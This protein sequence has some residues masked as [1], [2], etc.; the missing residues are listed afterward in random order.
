LLHA[1]VFCGCP[2]MA[3]ESPAELG[4]N[5]CSLCPLHPLPY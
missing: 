3:K 5:N 1:L 4:L 2:V